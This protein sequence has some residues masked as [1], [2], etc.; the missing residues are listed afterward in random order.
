MSKCDDCGD[1]IVKYQWQVGIKSVGGDFNYRYFD[2]KKDANKEYKMLV[3]KVRKGSPFD[4]E[5]KDCVDFINP[6]TVIRV[7]IARFEDND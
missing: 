4:W 2:N 6:K 3:A 5:F 7:R 1:K